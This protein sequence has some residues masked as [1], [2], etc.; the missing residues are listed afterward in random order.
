MQA[1]CRQK[2][3]NIAFF[4]GNLSK[5]DWVAPLIADPPPMGKIH[6]SSKIAVTIESVMQ[7]PREVGKYKLS[8]DY[9]E[10]WTLV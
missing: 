7:G 10:N 2:S 8:G 6:Q 5:L 1:Q 9:W 4:E 3:F